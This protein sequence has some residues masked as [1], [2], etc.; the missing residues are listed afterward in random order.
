MGS[1]RGFTMQT[2][3]NKLKKDGNPK[4]SKHRRSAQEVANSQNV[5]VVRKLLQEV[6]DEATQTPVIPAEVVRK[7]MDDY[8]PHSTGIVAEIYKNKKG[9]Q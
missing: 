8:L 9:N 5:L 4:A 3:E 2:S 6:R 7:L 1:D